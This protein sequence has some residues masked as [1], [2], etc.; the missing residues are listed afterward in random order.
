MPKRR[1]FMPEV[2]ACVAL[3]LLAGEH[4][5]AEVCKS[6]HVLPQQVKR[7][8]EELEANAHLAFG[9]GEEQEQLK[10][11]IAELERMVGR[12]TMQVEI[13]KKASTLLD[14]PP[15][16]RR[17]VA[18]M[19]R[20]SYPLAPICK[21]LGLSRS[22]FYYQ[23]KPCARNGIGRMWPRNGRSSKSSV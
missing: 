5:Q 13:L 15:A 20:Q 16:R 6:H 2:K 1:K 18:G 17:E 23:P 14:A 8:R 7:R 10:G 4:T 3:A 12:L 9:G 11:R 21:A 22:S 19:M